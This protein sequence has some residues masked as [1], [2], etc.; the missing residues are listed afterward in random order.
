MT[1][2][3]T[4][5]T[6]LRTLALAF[7]T[8]PIVIGIALVF[9]A[10]PA[11]GESAKASVGIVA[12]EIVIAV[13]AELLLETMGYRI[14]PLDAT[15]D[16]EKAASQA[17]VRFQASMI[18][19]FALAEVVVLIS[20]ALTFVVTP[21]TVLNYL[22]GAALGVALILIHVWPSSRVLTRCAAA[23]DRDG[24]RS[25]LVERLGKNT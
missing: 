16:A 19:R 20:I 6:T 3:V 23:M 10:K 14:K 15:M 21:L 22:V 25:Q 8:T 24:G 12:A 2:P 4:P 11:N 13:L 1:A 7:A 9:V 17:G 5:A 18:L